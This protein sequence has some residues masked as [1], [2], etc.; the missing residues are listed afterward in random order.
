MIF[1]QT[2]GFAYTLESAHIDLNGRHF[3]GV[4]SIKWQET[5]DGAEQVPGAAGIFIAE[6]RGTY[7]A[8]CEF[9]ILWS[10]YVALVQGL[11]SGY[12]EK[13]FNIGAQVQDTG[14]GL[15]SLFIPSCRIIDKGG[16]LE[17]NKA[18]VKSVKCSVM[19]IITLDGI[20]AISQGAL[21][22]GGSVGGS[23]SVVAQLGASAGFSL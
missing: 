12:M 5:M 1:P 15:S 17:R 11:G 2:T 22:F 18:S 21:S 23:A 4:Q 7:K 9:E 20:S 8:T 16:S 14:L 19:G 13:R 6:T 3:V 10:E